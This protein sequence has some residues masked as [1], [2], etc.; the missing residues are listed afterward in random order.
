MVS[1]V[2]TSTQNTEQTVS[3]FFD[4]VRSLNQAAPEVKKIS[5]TAFQSCHRKLVSTYVKELTILEKAIGELKAR[6]T[7]ELEETPKASARTESKA[8]TSIF[9]AAA[10]LAH[11]N[12]ERMVCQGTLLASVEFSNRLS[13]SRQALSK[14]L[15]SHRVFYVDFMSKRYFPAFYADPTYQRVQLE[16]V[17]KVLGDLPGGAKMQFFFT[18]KGSLGGDTP[19]EALLKGKLQKVKDVAAAFADV[20]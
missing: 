18:Q 19:L 16:A 20:R 13:W 1:A 2:A 14:A 5:R 8:M 15:G 12:L 7:E 17:T 6:F 9:Q 10:D 3:A 4:G 11:T